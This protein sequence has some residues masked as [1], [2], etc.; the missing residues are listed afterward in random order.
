LPLFLFDDVRVDTAAFR[1]ERGGRA[2]A[3]EPKAFDLLVLLLERQGQVVTKQEILDAVWPQTAVTDNA[4]TRIV[5]HLRKALGDDARDARYIETVP[6]RG[7]RW[8]APAERRE[9]GARTR[10]ACPALAAAR[11]AVR[12]WPS[13]PRS[14]ALSL[15]YRQG[16]TRGPETPAVL[17]MWPTQVTVSP[18]LDVFPALSPDGRAVAYATDRS[19]GFEIV[20]K[21]LLG[22]ASEIALTSDGQQNV[23]PAWSPDGDYVAY[24]S[25]RRGGIWIVPA[26][27]GVPRQVC[28]FGS[29]PAWSPDGTPARL[30]VRPLADIAPNAYGAN[31]PSTI[32]TVGARR[33]RPAPDHVF[34]RPRGRPRRAHLVTGRPGTSRSRPTPRRRA[35]SGPSPRRAAPPACS[36]RRTARS[37]TPSSLRTGAGSITRRADR[38]SSAFPWRRAAA[39]APTRRSPLPAWPGCAISR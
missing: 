19:G 2:V 21:P 34:R 9:E 27:G 20:V 3:L 23:E 26:L 39:P 15:A 8:L 14:A 37:S 33:R 30:P 10:P 7:Y 5:A 29:D 11:L 35:A 25:M 18:R 32:W 1:V 28:D 17:S 16:Q 24:H 22:G 38:S 36:T 31:V 4:M 13:W 12:R 6:T